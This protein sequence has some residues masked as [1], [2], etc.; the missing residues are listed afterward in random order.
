M[1]CDDYSGYKAG[2]ELGITEVACW[3]H[4]RRKF[5]ELQVHHASPIAEKA[6]DY[7][8]ALYAIERDAAELSSEARYEI[9]QTRAK[10]I[11]GALHRWLLSER[12]GLPESGRRA[13]AIDY[14]LKRWLAL[15]HYLDDG[16][17]RID[18]NWVEN[19]IKPWVLGRKNWLFAG[20]LRN[21]ERTANVMTLIQS[22]KM[23]GL[24]P[25]QYLK[26]VT[27]CLPT[28]RLQILMACCHITGAIKSR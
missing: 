28:A 4:A 9:R 19:Q 12:D 2:F 22:A 26:A 16:S 23:N 20:S 17:T 10:P 8:G 24:C 11:L 7:I 18:N 14:T 13:R 15:N 1:A 27:E 3:A 21:G 5:H 6:M 25:H